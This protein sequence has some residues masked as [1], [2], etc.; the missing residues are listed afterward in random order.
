MAPRGCFRRS[1][2][3]LRALVVAPGVVTR[4]VVAPGVV[5]RVVVACGVVTRVVGVFGVVARARPAVLGVL[6]WVV[7]GRGGVSGFGRVWRRCLGSW[8]RSL[9]WVVSVWW[10]R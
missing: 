1:S 9:V 10:T 6:A 3:P 2:R 7:A 4:V 8:M 5:T